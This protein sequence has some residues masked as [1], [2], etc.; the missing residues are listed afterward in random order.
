VVVFQ[1]HRYSRTHALAERFGES[2]GDAE[3]VLVTDVYAAGEKPIPGAGPERIVESAKARGHAHV[4][5][6]GDLAAAEVRL[7]ALVRSGDLLLTLGAGDVWKVGEHFVAER[8]RT[9]ERS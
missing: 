9:G 4:E 5:Y 7:A 3:I 2:F 1:P 6:V 8:A